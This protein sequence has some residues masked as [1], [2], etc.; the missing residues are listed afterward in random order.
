MKM[1]IMKSLTTYIYDVTTYGVMLYD[2][3]QSYLLIHLLQYMLH[4]S[5]KLELMRVVPDVNFFH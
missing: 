3:Y 5:E 4:L 2:Q 1:L